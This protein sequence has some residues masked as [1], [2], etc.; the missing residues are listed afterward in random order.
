M[1]PAQDPVSGF[2]F[3]WALSAVYW[4][5]WEESKFPL[6]PEN[7]TDLSFAAM[8]QAQQFA[9]HYSI[10]FHSMSAYFG[11]L[12]MNK[13]PDKGHELTDKMEGALQAIKPAVSKIKSDSSITYDEIALLNALRSWHSTQSPNAMSTARK[14]LTRV[15]MP[16]DLQKLFTKTAESQ[17]PHLQ[18]LQ[19]IV[20]QLTGKAGYLVPMEKVEEARK[21][22]PELWPQYLAAKKAADLIYKQ[23]LHNYVSEQG[24]PQPVDEVRNHLEDKGVMAHRLPPKTFVGKIDAEGHL[25]TEDGK[26]LSMQTLY[27]GAK[28]T[29][30]PDYDP[31]KD[32]EAGKN[33]N[34]YLKAVLPT[35]NAK[36][37]NNVQY[38]YVDDKRKANKTAKFD[39]VQQMLK[40][41][42]KIVGAWRKDLKSEHASVAVPAAQCEISY[43]TAARI[44][45]KDNENKKGKTYGLTTWLVGNV[46]RRGTSIIFDYIGK[47]SVHQ[48]HV[49]SPETAPEKEVIKIVEALMEGKKRTD[50]LWT[51]GR[52]SFNDSNLRKYFATV[53]PIPGATVHKIRH[54]RGTSLALSL[55]PALE[56]KMMKSRK[57]SQTV[58]DAAVKE[59]LTKV[60]SLLGHVRGVEGE[61]KATWATA[62]KNYVD[63]SVIQAFYAKFADRGIR[64]PKWLV[65]L[66]K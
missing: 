63:P 64:E 25:Y 38:V 61:A 49:I 30:N 42:K 66:T 22:N 47:D 60:G 2:I 1:S 9:S 12:L 46:R 56:E 29:M 21:N 26:K 62:A 31:D 45:G 27:P 28:I 16:K 54:M 3:L 19:E 59:A 36:G 34:W 8:G 18:K 14:L 35:K 58:L 55:L 65:D 40:Q 48:K 32:N 11:W 51:F 15:N 57:L 20:K 52:R 43:L 23:E 41:E 17:T 37:E 39:V 24:G 33:G 10:S 44:G 5:R 7:M 4:Q 50:P 6:I 13:P 53:C